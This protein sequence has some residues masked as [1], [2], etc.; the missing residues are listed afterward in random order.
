[1][2]SL[3]QNRPLFGC[4]AGLGL[5]M[6]LGMSEVSMGLNQWMEIEALPEGAG[7]ALTLSRAKTQESNSGGHTSSTECCNDPCRIPAPVTH[8]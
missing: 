2:A 1:M 5:L 7:P 6:L 3:T 4:L 8:E